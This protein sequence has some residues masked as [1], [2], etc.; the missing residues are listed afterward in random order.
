MKQIL[1]T[2]CAVS[3]IA[4]AQIQE[5]M[6]K[7]SIDWGT[8]TVQAVGIGAPN[9]NLPAVAARPAAI[10]AARDI[11]LRNALEIIQGIQLSSSTTVANYMLENDRIQTQVSGF[12]RTFKESDP[13]YMSDKTIEITVSVPL[14]GQMNEA[15]LPQQIEKQPRAIPVATKSMGKSFSGLIIDARGLKVLPALSPQIFNE[16]GK[17]IYGTAF[18]ARDFAVKWGVV[19]YAKTPEQAQGMKDRIGEKPGIIKAKAS[20]NGGVDLVVS[21]TDAADIASAA[22]SENFLADCRVIVLVD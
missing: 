1:L 18:V 2:M 10:R 16:D 12:I 8:R 7:G 22:K 3:G 19:G 21:N 4:F 13:K 5:V 14:D 15:L 6:G 17:E 9:P 11:A 20:K